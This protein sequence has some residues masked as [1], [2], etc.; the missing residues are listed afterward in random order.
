MIIN[1]YLTGSLETVLEHGNILDPLEPVRYSVCVDEETTHDHQRNNE[2]GHES[3]GEFHVGDENRDNKSVGS[4]V[5][6]DQNR[7]EDEH[8]EAVSLVD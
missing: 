1:F 8:P 2:D 5:P 3:H 4:S 7:D 6:V